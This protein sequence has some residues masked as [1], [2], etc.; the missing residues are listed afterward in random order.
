M[1]LAGPIKP[2]IRP[3]LDPAFV[4]FYEETLATK[5]ALHQIPLEQIRSDPRKYAARWALDALREGYERVKDWDVATTD[6]ATIKAR[7]YHP[8]PEKAGPGPY[9]VHVNYH[10]GG[11]MFGDLTNDAEWCLHIRD[12]LPLV[13]VDVA[14]RLCPEV[15]YGHNIED[16]WS[17]LLWVRDNGKRLNINPGSV[18]IGGLSAGAQFAAILQHRARDI[19]LPLKLAILAVP[20]MAPHSEYRS[21]EDSPFPSF[22]E[23][24]EGPVLS[25]ELIKY[26]NQCTFPEKLLQSL[27][28][29]LP[30]YYFSPLAAP[31]FRGICDT[32]IATAGCDPLRDEGEA[33]GR[34]LIEGGSKVTIKRYAGVPHTFLHMTSILQQ[35]V[36]YEKSRREFENELDSHLPAGQDPRAQRRALTE[37][38]GRVTM[39]TMQRSDPFLPISP[40]RVK[41]LVLPVGPIHQDRFA[42]FLQRLIGESSVQLRDISADGRPNRNMFNPLAFPVGFIFYDLITHVP[43]PS[44]LALTPFDQYREPL[45]VLALADGAAIKSVLFGSRRQ[46]AAGRSIEERNIR[47]LY[48][49]LEALRDTYPRVL[50]HRV[51]IFDYE[52]S[53]ETPIPIPEGMATVSSPAQSKR[54][55]MRMVMCDVSSLLLAEMNTLAKSFE[56]MSYIESPAQAGGGGGSDDGHGSSHSSHSSHSSA[57]PSRRN[58]QFALPAHVGGGVMR[59]SS[60]KGND[61]SSAAD[62]SQV[63]MSMPAPARDSS[64]TSV[65]GRPSTPVRSGLSGPATTFD[66]IGKTIPSPERNASPAISDSA[67][68]FRFQGTPIGSMSDHRVSVQ[69]FGSGGLNERWRNKGKSRVTIVVA[70]LYLQAGRW[71]D[72]LKE[73]IDG[74]TVSRSNN[75]HVWHGKALELIVV[76]LFLLGWADIEFQVPTICLPPPEKGAAAAATAHA[77]EAAERAH[78]N[79]PR[80]L[81]N[82]QQILPDLLERILGLYGRISAERL[83]PLAMAE[84]TIRFCNILTAL[85]TADGVLGRAF[86]DIVVV[87]RSKAEEIVARTMSP[88]PGVVPGRPQILTSV[89]RAFPAATAADLMLSTVDRIVILSGIASVLG[90]LNYR[91]KRALVVRELLSVLTDGLVE[92]RTR[93][94]AEL[95]IHPAAGLVTPGSGGQGSGSGVALDLAEG[96][97]ETGVEA[98]LGLLLR[99]YGVVELQPG[100]QTDNET[101]KS[102]IADTDE[103]V[104]SRI[105]GQAAARQFGVP[106]LKMDIL[107]ACIN[108]SEALPDFGGVA[109]FSSDLLRTAGSGV[110]PGPRREDAAAMIT[111]DEQVR[112]ATNIAKATGLARR[113]GLADVAAEYWDEFLVRG[114]RLELPPALCVPVAH[115]ESELP[116]RGGKAAVVTTV[117]TSQDVDP[118]IHNPFLKAVDKEVVEQTLVAMEPATFRLTLQNPFDME[119]VIDSIRLETTGVAFEAFEEGVVVGPYRTQ[120]VRVGGIPQAPGSLNVTGAI[121]RVHGCRERRFPILRQPWMRERADKI[122]AIGVAPFEEGGSGN[123]MGSS[124]VLA[125][126]KL[127]LQ[128][129]PAQPLVV[130]QSTTLAQSSAMILEG[131]RQAFSVTLQNLSLT[132]AVDF[133]IFSFQDSTQATMQAALESRDASPAELYEYELM[134]AKRPAL[135]LRGRKGGV[136]EKTSQ[137]RYI[138]PG[139]TATFDFE[140]LGKPGLTDGTIQMDYAYLG[141]TAEGVAADVVAGGQFHTRQVSL[142]LTVTVNASVEVVRMDVLPLHGQI[143]GPLWERCGGERRKPDPDSFCLLLMDLRNAWPSDMRVRLW[144]GG[145]SGGDGSDAD[146]TAIE[147]IL[148]GNTCR[149][150]VPMRRIYLEDPHASIPALN[151]AR[152]RQFVVSTS[153]ISPDMERAT[154]ETFWY[155]ERMLDL[156]RGEWT[157]GGEEGDWASGH[158]FGRPAVRKGAIELRSI[159]LT[160][161]MIEAVKV[162][163]VDDFM[164]LRVRITNRTARPIHPL[165]RLMPSLCHRPHNVALDFTRKFAWNG[166][167]QQGLAL[168]GPRASTIVRIGAT[169]LCRGEFEVTA[170]VE[171]T[172][173]WVPARG[174]EE[175]AEAR[176]ADRA[177][178]AAGRPR[179]NTE[180]L[181][182]DSMLGAKERRIW[183]SRAP[184]HFVVTD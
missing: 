102:V 85:H 129:I 60:L 159:R 167:L 83:P 32:F 93:G 54:T 92:A 156:L 30:E 136:D 105:G 158:G 183:H 126:E 95:G 52:S 142:H 46:S 12:D 146:A 97:L 40:A 77:L 65:T 29:T 151:P 132:T 90:R 88:R 59:S 139:E 168:L 58:S 26:F 169:A 74:A 135:R 175:E 181:L 47:T 22:A 111:R 99:T 127:S 115:S 20:P 35:S 28:Q 13:I 57:L 3:K 66:E 10:G 38:T 50:V 34:K 176:R 123:M 9:P 1:A 23:F 110:A 171:E 69:G 143:P 71:T 98:F 166:T 55:T 41:A 36:D 172:R 33:Y 118:F 24:A 86:L 178:Q 125:A 160:M 31:N 174:E 180:T 177:D 73:L 16:A 5:P 154:R 133:L 145:S 8:D 147:H 104:F 96:D 18:S 45:V 182:M 87:G 53:P 39:A 17:A 179:S 134:L 113:L 19:K 164:Q 2:D 150:L 173:L 7:S 144:T 109:K 155:R 89:L 162:E 37:R 161:R 149:V 140:L 131:E 116:I 15:N 4:K 130:V 170:S 21:A 70:S 120:I 78:P 165:L 94:A 121:V 25:W 62:R 141:V 137:N 157:T 84:T 64:S 44:H 80:W 112:L 163:E 103:A 100:R 117:R 153:K 122:K 43:Q 148:P 114:V 79:Q 67:D 124:G 184:C 119:V 128:V 14:Y 75:D 27:R 63:R 6:E 101:A 106:S 76:C 51:L 42:S 81:R 138:G 48:Q 56:A 72:A 152:Q 108:F 68:S 107:R 82:L 91:R 61:H 49:E 11:Y